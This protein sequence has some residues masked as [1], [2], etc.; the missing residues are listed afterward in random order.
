MDYDLPRSVR[1]LEMQRIIGSETRDLLDAVRAENP[2]VSRWLRLFASVI[3]ARTIWRHHREAVA[4]SRVIGVDWREL[5]LAAVSYEYVIGMFACSTVAIAT[6]HGPMIARN[7]DWW[8]ERELARAS[9]V[10]CHFRGQH[11]YY[12]ASW[13]GALGVVTGM[14]ENFALAMNAVG[15]PEGVRRTGYPVMLFL[16]R[17]LEKARSFEQ[18]VEWLCRQRLAASCLVT[19]VGDKNHERVCV[20]RT[21]T[22]AVVRRPAGEDP[23]V[24]TNSY[25]KMDADSAGLA[26]TLLLT[27]CSRREALEE[28]ARQLGG[29]PADEA[30]LYTLTDGRVQQRITSQ[31]VLMRPATFDFRLFVPRNLLESDDLI[32]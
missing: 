2:T 12:S 7:M 28:L 25:Q 21:P 3:D 4:L 1:Y 26:N 29:A 17:V 23:L 8:P 11:T 30:L 27:S 16:R 10:F 31:H 9:Y 14:T 6:E 32:E 15:S 5:M 18:A 20:E 22:K 13:P 24:T 19:V